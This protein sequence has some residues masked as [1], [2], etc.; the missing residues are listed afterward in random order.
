MRQRIGLRHKSQQPSVPHGRSDSLKPML[1]FVEWIKASEF[2]GYRRIV[3]HWRTINFAV[4]PCFCHIPDRPRRV[5]RFVQ[6]NLRAV[7]MPD[8]VNILLVHYI[9]ARPEITVLELVRG[10]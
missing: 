5:R 6:P 10:I 4:D 1:R 9:G 2:G 8:T 7:V 3:V